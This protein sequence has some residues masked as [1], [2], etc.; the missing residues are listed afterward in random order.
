MLVPFA[1]DC[2]QAA[3]AIRSACAL[4]LKS[5]IKPCDSCA[6]D[7]AASRRQT[8]EKRARPSRKAATVKAKNCDLYDRGG[9]KS[10]ATRK[11]PISRPAREKAEG[12]DLSID[13]EKGLKPA[14]NRHKRPVFYLSVEG[15]TMREMLVFSENVAIQG[16][17]ERAP[18]AAI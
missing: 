6:S 12:G 11:R 13:P 17:S 5:S 18:R 7:Q 3:A 16:R 9:H 2:N 15:H 10:A 1:R 8:A 4:G 14:Q